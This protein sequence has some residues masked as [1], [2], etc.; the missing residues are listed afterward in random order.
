[1]SGIYQG[2]H[3][4]C[5]KTCYSYF[6]VQGSSFLCKPFYKFTTEYS[7]NQVVYFSTAIVGYNFTKT[8]TVESL[9]CGH[10]VKCSVWR[11]ILISEVNLYYESILGK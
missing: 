8:Y 4:I 6:V 7:K 2:V 5:I 1:M 3:N 10:L 9:C 11:G